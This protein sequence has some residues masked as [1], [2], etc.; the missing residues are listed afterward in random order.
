MASRANHV[1]LHRS[2]QIP[3]SHKGG[4]HDR[5]T[6]SCS[7]LI[8]C[9]HVPLR[10]RRSIQTTS[11]RFLDL[12]LA[13]TLPFRGYKARAHHARPPKRCPQCLIQSLPTKPDLLPSVAELQTEMVWLPQIPLVCIEAST[14]EKLPAVQS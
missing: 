12:A 8:S 4:L 9:S 2:E 10:T 5:E 13:A 11:F 7:T 1:A 14:S 3:T 6:V